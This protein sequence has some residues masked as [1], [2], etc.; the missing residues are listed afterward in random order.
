MSIRSLLVFIACSVLAACADDGAVPVAAEQA[1]RDPDVADM[2]TPPAQKAPIRLYVFDCGRVSFESVAGFGLAE[3]DTAS[4]EVAVPCYIIDHP[5]GQLLWD[6]GLPSALANQGQWVRRGDGFEVHLTT[7]LAHQLQAMDLGFGLDS[8]EYVAFSH[9]HWDHV[10]AANDITSGEW[11]VQKGDYAGVV[12]AVNN[13][14]PAVELALLEGMKDRPT[15][16]LEGDHDVFGDGRVRII[17][18]YGHTPGHQVLYVEL[19]DTGPVVLSGDLYHFRVSRTQRVVPPFNVD[20]VQTLQ[21]MT[22]VEA[23]VA[24]TG[25]DLWIQHDLARFE[26]Q[27]R[28]PGFYQ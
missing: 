18:A 28:A 17:A 20:K 13:P 4:R 22:R 10:G 7:T 16:V 27:T 9:I 21:A 2:A 1:G 24:E 8:L 3:T 6:A 25:S 26:G 23:L 11:L 15:R 14:V 5:E 19:A 12:D